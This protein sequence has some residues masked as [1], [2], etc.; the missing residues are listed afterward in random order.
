MGAAGSWLAREI[1]HLMP[2]LL[3]FLVAFNLLALTA[4]LSGA[5]G[6]L[7]SYATA[8]LSALVCGKAVLLADRLPFF[9]RFP[10]RPLIWNVV[11][12]ALLYTLITLAIRLVESSFDAWRTD[13]HLGTGAEEMIAHFTWAHFTMIQL[14]LALLFL[15]YSAFH[16]L[17]EAVGFERTWRLFFGAPETRRG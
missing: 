12:K 11:W 3:F 2:P 7:L 16:E 15:V 14:W 8:S 13:P 1:R 10:D 5:R 17:M 4:E 9:N 6:G